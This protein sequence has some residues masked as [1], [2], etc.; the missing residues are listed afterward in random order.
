MYVF[1]LREKVSRRDGQRER[2]ELF[3]NTHSVDTGAEGSSVFS[4]GLKEVGT[5][6]TNR[7]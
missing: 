5:A 6:E 2:D 7:A 4:V 3:A 1:V